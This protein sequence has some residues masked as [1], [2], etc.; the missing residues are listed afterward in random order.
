[1]TLNLSDFSGLKTVMND[2]A[3]KK[4]VVSGISQSPLKLDKRGQTKITI[5]PN[6]GIVIF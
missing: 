1:M 2:K 3:D 5:Q 4:G 6:G